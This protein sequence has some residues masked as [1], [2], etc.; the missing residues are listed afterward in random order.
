M[1]VAVTGMAEA[2]DADMHLIL[3]CV[4]ILYE[5]IYLVARYNNV[6]L[7]HHG[8][9]AADSLQE[10]ASGL[11]DGIGTLIGIGNQYIDGTLLQAELG[12]CII[13]LG[14]I[15][16]IAAIELQQEICIC[17]IVREALT[18][19]ILCVHDNLTLHELDSG[20]SC[21]GLYNQW[22]SA[23]SLSQGRERYQQADSL[24]RQRQQLQDSLGHK[25]QSTLGTDNHIL[26]IVAGA[27]LYN[28]AAYF[29]DGAVSQDNLQAP[30]EITGYTILYSAHAACI[31]ADVAADGSSLLTWIRR[32]EQSLRLNILIDLHQQYARLQSQG[33]V[34]LIQLQ[35]VVHESGVNHDTMLYSYGST[36]QAGTCATR[37]NG[38]VLLV[39]ILQYAGNLLSRCSAHNQIRIGRGCSQLIMAVFLIYLICPK[40]ALTRHNLGNLS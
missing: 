35:E 29:H 8:S 30:D 28:L 38:D 31:S 10:G 12:N 37:G 36:Y 23:D 13:I 16:G 14:N 18:Q 39:G 2:L 34:F 9:G 21:L 33:E 1:E 20:R 5:L 22:H 32:I 26:Q 25:C 17:L 15:L 4:Y 6:Y 40:N 11:P 3:Q 27:V 7:V 19:E 24:L